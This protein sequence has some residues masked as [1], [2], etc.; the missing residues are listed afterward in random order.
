MRRPAV[1][2]ETKQ[3][4]AKMS[5]IP[6]TAPLV[7][8]DNPVLVSKSTDRKNKV[9]S[10]HFNATHCSSDFSLLCQSRS[11]QSQQPTVAVVGGGGPI[12]SPP[13]SKL[14]PVEAQKNQQTEEILDS[15]LPPRE[16]TEDGQLWVQRVSSTP[17]TRLDVIN[18][19]VRPSPSTR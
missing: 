16:W 6:A 5:M 13:K 1:S 18:L 9:L 4:F 12:P 10:T 7:K 3:P 2:T 8:Y 17:A 14:P 19:Q 15:V 11:K